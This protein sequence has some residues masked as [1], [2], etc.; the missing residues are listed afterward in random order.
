MNTLAKKIEEE[1]LARSFMLQH[2]VTTETTVQ[3]AVRRW[4]AP[5]Q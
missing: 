3:S 2:A 4:M 1:A 5:M